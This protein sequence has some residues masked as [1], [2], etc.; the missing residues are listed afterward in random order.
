VM[1]RFPD[2]KNC[3]A[4]RNGTFCRVVQTSRELRHK[5]ARND[6]P[7]DTLPA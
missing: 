5:A 2:T 4:F 3:T 1:F 7:H 6:A